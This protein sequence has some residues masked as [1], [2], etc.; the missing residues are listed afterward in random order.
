MKWGKKHICIWH[1]GVQWK[2]LTEVTLRAPSCG[3][4]PWQKSTG[5]ISNTD[6]GYVQSEKGLLEGKTRG[7]PDRSLRTTAQI[8]VTQL[9]GGFFF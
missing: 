2:Q 4:L 3:P 5:W 6:D 7:T 8:Q 9:D 1:E